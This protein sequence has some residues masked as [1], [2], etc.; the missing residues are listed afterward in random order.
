MFKRLKAHADKTG[1]K[2]LDAVDVHF[3]PQSGVFNDRVDAVTA[4]KR[5]RSVRSLWD[6]GYTDESWI[7]ETIRLL[8]RMREI[9]NES[10]P[11]LDLV[12]GDGVPQ[13]LSSGMVAHAPAGTT[14]AYQIAVDGT[15]FLTILSAGEGHA[16]FR[17][18]D[19]EVTMPPDI[20]DVVRVAGTHGITFPG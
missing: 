14:H 13:R 15:R 19:A 17:Q 1:V 7:G 6:S 12:I 4:A 20:A 11:G 3:Y 2:L 5:I 8:P 9:I 18:M 16:F 10:W